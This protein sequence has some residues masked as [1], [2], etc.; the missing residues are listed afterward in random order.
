[1]LWFRL[2]TGWRN[3]LSGARLR[4]R[5]YHYRTAGIHMLMPFKRF[6]ALLKL[7][8]RPNDARNTELTQ[9]DCNRLGE[10]L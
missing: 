5:L 7:P 9:A 3:S 1:M 10:R 6:V 2:P 8:N 4:N